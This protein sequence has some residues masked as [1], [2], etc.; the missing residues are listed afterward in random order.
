MGIAV[1]ANRRVA[2]Q[3]FPLLRI[4]RYSKINPAAG[5][6]IKVKLGLVSVVSKSDSENQR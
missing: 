6:M 4:R 5:T 3:F 2:F 1:A